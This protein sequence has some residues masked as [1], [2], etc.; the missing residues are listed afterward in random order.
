MSLHLSS[1]S[2]NFLPQDRSW[3]TLWNIARGT[4]LA[5]SMSLSSVPVMSQSI[6]TAVASVA[7]TAVDIAKWTSS[8]SIKPIDNYVIVLPEGSRI[9]NKLIPTS[10][11]L[12][13]TLAIDTKKIHGVQVN[14]APWMG[15]EIPKDKENTQKK[16]ILFKFL[17]D[18]IENHP[19]LSTLKAIHI[20]TPKIP[21]FPQLRE[22]NGKT[23]YHAHNPMIDPNMLTI[24]ISDKSTL[25]DTM[26]KDILSSIK[27]RGSTTN[28][29]IIGLLAWLIVAVF[30]WYW[31]YIRGRWRK[32]DKE[33]KTYTKNNRS[34][35][36]PSYEKTPAESIRRMSRVEPSNKAK[37]IT[38]S[39]IHSTDSV[40]PSP[41]NEDTW[42]TSTQQY[43]ISTTISEMLT[44]LG[45]IVRTPT[46]IASQA[47]WTTL[48]KNLTQIRC[49]CSKWEKEFSI[50]V[51]EQWKIYMKTG[52]IKEDC[53]PYS[54]DQLCTFFKNNQH[55]DN[56][57]Q[58]NPPKQSS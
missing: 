7:Q 3:N 13:Y 18:T 42:K 28:W 38:I 34:I 31:E 11:S 2:E 39:A 15:L 6:D 47:I 25:D 50:K 52:N 21:G 1:P 10:T 37:E 40:R 30:A 19:K 55:I 32:N 23:I 5:I 8:L 17:A 45:Y 54:F 57:I 33:T 9:N 35:L 16:Q 58:E 43:E 44:E 29:V 56:K 49:A 12:F 46:C 24:T 4:A 53:K 14:I 22:I 26:V 41:K 20:T 51:T 27:Q 48:E 36:E